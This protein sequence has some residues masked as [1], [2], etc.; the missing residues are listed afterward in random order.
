[1]TPE[2]NLTEKALSDTLS[3]LI[4]RVGGRAFAVPMRSVE[5][6]VRMAALTALPGVTCGVVGALHL[7]GTIVPVVDPRPY[8]GIDPVSIS[9]E[10][11]LIVMLAKGRYVLWVDDVERIVLV[12][13]ADLDAVELGSERTIAPYV[14]RLDGP[15]VP[16]LSAEALDPGPIVR[17]VEGPPW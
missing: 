17:P 11:R 9:P 10:Q 8:L 3:L 7:A 6:I 5:R 12:S 16:V 15:A 14:A 13:Q 4:V 1:M 2:Q